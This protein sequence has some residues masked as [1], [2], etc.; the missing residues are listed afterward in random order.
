MA[1]ISLDE[2]YLLRIKTGVMH[3]LAH[4]DALCI[5]LVEPLG[6]ELPTQCAGGQKRG[7]KALAFL[8]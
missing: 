1:R 3:G 5:G 4:G 8:F 7:S 6:L 2:W